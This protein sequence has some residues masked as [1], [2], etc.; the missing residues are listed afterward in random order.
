M[1]ADRIVIGVLDDLGARARPW[2]GDL[3]A[4]CN[5][6]Q[7]AVCHQ[8]NTICQQDRLIDV[9]GD[10]KDGLVRSAPDLQQLFLD[11]APCQRIKCAKGFIQQQQL[12]FV[13]CSFGP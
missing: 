3:D 12:G 10:H 11:R 1:V 6:R 7:W 5:P 9:V 4:F 13:C 8:Q 2:N